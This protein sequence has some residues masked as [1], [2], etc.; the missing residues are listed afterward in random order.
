MPV[1]IQPDQE[2]QLDT[3]K[4]HELRVRLQPFKVVVHRDPDDEDVQDDE[5]RLT[6]VDNSKLQ[7]SI[8]LTDEKHAKEIQEGQVEVTFP[9][10]PDG[11][12]T[13]FLD[14]G[15]D[16]YGQAEGGYTIFE[17][18]PIPLVAPPPKPAKKAVTAGLPPGWAEDD[19]LLE[20]GDE[21]VDID[22]EDELAL[23]LEG[24]G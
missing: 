20:L 3:T 5:L 11:T 10:V 24:G 13:L 18:T 2:A 19:S 4:H 21:D 14:M 6:N 16:R 12:Y 8:R 17:N 23:L 15:L 9:H 7:K 1:D 22:D